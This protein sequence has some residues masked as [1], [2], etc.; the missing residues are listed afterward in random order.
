MSLLVQL[1]KFYKNESLHLPHDRA[2]LFEIGY[3]LANLIEDYGEIGNVRRI[4]DDFGFDNLLITLRS[5]V[6]DAVLIDTIINALHQM[7]LNS[8]NEASETMMRLTA[9]NLREYLLHREDNVWYD[10]REVEIENEREA[11]ARLSA[12]EEE[13]FFEVEENIK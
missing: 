2:D 5:S 7:L 8:V 9:G 6:P 11:D 3:E 10:K 12:L 13:F 4:A 1:T